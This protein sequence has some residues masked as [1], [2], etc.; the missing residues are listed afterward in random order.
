M[1]DKKMTVTIEELEK[2]LLGEPI[3]TNEEGYYSIQQWADMWGVTLDNARGKIRK[4]TK[5]GM[6]D[7]GN[8]FSENKLGYRICLPGYKI[9]L[10]D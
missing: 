4:A 7:T 1:K 6:I 10:P 8:I 3:R 5:A 2:A 9:T